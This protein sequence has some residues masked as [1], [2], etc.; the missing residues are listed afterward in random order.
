VRGLRCIAKRALLPSSGTR[1][2]CA[3]ESCV[4]QPRLAAVRARSLPIG[5]LIEWRRPYCTIEASPH[6]RAGSARRAGGPGDSPRPTVKLATAEVTAATNNHLVPF[7]VLVVARPGAGRCD[8]RKRHE[9][10]RTDHQCQ[11]PDRRSR[12]ATFLSRA[13]ISGAG[14]ASAPFSRHPSLNFSDRDPHRM[15]E[16]ILHNRSFGPCLGTLRRS[17]SEVW[18]QSSPD[19]QFGNR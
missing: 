2:Q 3:A 11:K 16:A 13:A 12:H 9:R 7:D 5:I 10:R 17:R 4:H 6:A 15:E 8:R 1:E 19:R 18:Q 14:D